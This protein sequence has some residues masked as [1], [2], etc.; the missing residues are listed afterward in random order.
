MSCDSDYVRS[1]VPALT[2]DWIFFDNAGGSQTLQRVVDRIGEFLLSSNVQLG[3]SYAVSVAA[4]ERLLQARRRL[5]QLINAAR[6][7]EIVMGP[8]TTQQL[9]SLAQ[10]LAGQFQPGDEILVSNADHEVNLSPWLEL[11][12]QGVII[13]FWRFDPQS[14]ELDLN[15]LDQLMT[16]RTRL[17]CFTH[18]SNIFGSIN[19]VA[20]ISR[21]VHDRGARVCVDAVAYAPHRL[22]DVQA[23][24]RRCGPV[25]PDFDRPKL[26][27][28]CKRTEDIC[29]DQ[30]TWPQ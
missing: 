27:S 25:D 8:T 23:K 19:P 22:I 26:V 18:T 16:A 2:G 30:W 1:Q 5:A 17:V 12:K 10:A 6:P 20:D 7:E 14:L 15:A 13:K 9:R 24:P 21:F 11:E 3:A 28:R 4:G 29:Y